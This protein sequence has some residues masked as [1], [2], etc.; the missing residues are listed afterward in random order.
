LQQELPAFHGHGGRAGNRWEPASG[1][2]KLSKI[3][4]RFG[5]KRWITPRA[6]KRKPFV[7]RKIPSN[8]GLRSLA[9]GIPQGLLYK[10]W[11]DRSGSGLLPCHFGRENRDSSPANI[12]YSRQNQQGE[13]WW[14]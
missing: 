3:V 7:R 10:T 1:E 12:R 14:D 6:R 13:R 2:N 8:A 11:P 5:V 9:A 4:K